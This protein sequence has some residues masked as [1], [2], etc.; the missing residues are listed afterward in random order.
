MQTLKIDFQ[1][2]DLPSL[3]PHDLLIYLRGLSI[4]KTLYEGLTRI[5]GQG[6][7]KLSGAKTVEVSPDRL[8]YT[9]T[10]RDNAWSDGTPV[11]AFQYENA[12]K[13]A[14]SPTSTCARAELLYMI[15]NAQEA[16]KGNASL[17]SVGVKAVDA[18]TLVVDLAY[19]SP[20]FLELLAQPVCAPL[21][22]PQQK[23]MREFNGPFMV[24]KWEKSSLLQLKPNPYFWDR[25]QVSLPEIDVYMIQDT[26]TAYSFFKEGKIDYIGVPLCNLTSEQITHLQDAKTLRSHPID[27][28]F[29][30]HLN[31]QH[32]AL[33][34]PLIR[35]ALSM[36]LHRQDITNHILLGGNPLLTP[37][38]S[39]L[40]PLQ[41]PIS[42]KEDIVEA[43]KR[44]EQGV[45]ELGLT[46]ETFP[47]LT[48]TY[49]PQANRK[50]MAEYLQN[51]WSSAL[52]IKVNV[53]LKDWNTLRNNL[54]KGLFE[55][56][57]TY[58]APYY[59]DPIELLSYFI[60][61]N[62][63]NYTQWVHPFYSD[64]IALAQ[65]EKEFQKR[66]QLLGEAEQFLTEQMPFIPICTDKLMY[67]HNPKLQGYVFDCLGAID[68]SY[69]SF[70]K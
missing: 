54:A 67:S 49:S 11:T 64:K 27:R 58:A 61:L 4:S 8:R 36:S 19:P 33:S 12:W 32:P 13:E 68:F 10:L 3:H 30:I 42:S 51:A 55:I 48:I 29:W 60:N 52:G 70:K 44:F 34:S 16:K 45:K 66:T 1:E 17:D 25:K 26:N 47:P 59:K 62:N 56:S 31:T 39:T 40:L 50:Q 46:K 15:K 14:L 57:F 63:C 24:S 53:E 20:Y 22:H 35:Q 43:K 23:E 5:D 18:K 37:L 21:L 7:A 2:G 65:Q 6:Q 69:A 9:F 28:V 38:P 41:I